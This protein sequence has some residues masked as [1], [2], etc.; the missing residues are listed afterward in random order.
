VVIGSTPIFAASDIQATLQFYRDVLGFD[1]SWTWGDPPT[2]GSV[3][4]NG[5]TIMFNLQ[6]DLAKQIEGHQH[7]FKC[8]AV[9]DL[10]RLHVERGA[11]IVSPIEDKPWGAREYV[12]RDLNGYH[13]R[14]AGNPAATAEPSEPFPEGVK[15]IRRKATPEEYREVVARAFGGPSEQ[16]GAD[17]AVLESTWG[18]VVAETA[19]GQVIGVVRIMRDGEGWYS[20]WNVAVLPEWQGRHI[21]HMMMRESLEVIRAESPGALVYLF[22]YK[23]GFYE[24]LGFA[25]ETVSMR[26][27]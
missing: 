3:S 5:N 23:H 7:W 4:L 2:F 19:E 27:V 10:Y 16:D 1:S 25:T 12:V 14:F 20:I 9:D 15:I 24:R 17:L 18:G 11:A 22:T 26:K 13:L 8:E 21:G 6:P